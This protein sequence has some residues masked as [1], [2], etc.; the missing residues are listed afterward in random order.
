MAAFLQFFPK[1]NLCP[2]GIGLEHVLSV[3]THNLWNLPVQDKQLRSNPIQSASNCS[4]F[5]SPW[6]SFVRQYGHLAFP[7][8]FCYTLDADGT[9]SSTFLFGSRALYEGQDTEG[10]SIYFLFFNIICI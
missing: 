4:H 7:H 6:H 1:H 8:Q 5:P 2:P 9:R 3:N 10:S